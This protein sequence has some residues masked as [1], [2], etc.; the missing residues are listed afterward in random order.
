MEMQKINVII[1]CVS[2]LLHIF[3]LITSICILIL[4]IYRLN[5][6]RH[7]RRR[8]SKTSVSLFEDSISL[9]LIGNTYLIF[10]AYSATWLFVL[11]Y[12]VAGDFSLFQTTLHFGDSN[13]CRAQVALIFFLTSAFF[14]SFLLQA[15][16]CFIKVIFH[17]TL[18]TKKLCYLPLNR[19]FT[20]ILLILASW[21][22][23]ILTLIPA[24][25]IFDVFSYLP[26]QYHCL[27]SFT[28]TRGFVYS[29]LSTYVI[30]VL[31]IIYIYSRLIMFI[32]HAFNFDRTLRARRE[33]QLV[34]RIL[35]ICG[36]LS[37]SGSPT[38][39]FLFQF[40]ITGKHHPMADRIH[41]FGVAIS[42]NIVTLGFAILN[43]LVNLLPA[44]S[45]V[46]R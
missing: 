13:A 45:A 36:I 24:F 25:T 19:T 41:E 17:S 1:N 38:L 2:V 16:R 46:R 42:T 14:H 23:S 35:T 31:V 32:H 22:I 4:I 12:T 37:F 34:K 5:F 29:V 8:V 26:E 20:Y 39:F 30:P 21:F 7:Y 43:S 28:N 11:F 3:S 18:H 9:L 40:I 15:L 6:N 44:R 10:I 27:I 33:K